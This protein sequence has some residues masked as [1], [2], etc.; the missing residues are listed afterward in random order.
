MASQGPRVALLVSIGVL[1]LWFLRALLISLRQAAGRGSAWVPST[2]T[3]VTG[4]VT[5]FFDTL[6]IGNF[7]TTTTIFRPGTWYPTSSFPAP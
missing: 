5:T 2:G 6:G 3:W 4:F 7:A 1:C